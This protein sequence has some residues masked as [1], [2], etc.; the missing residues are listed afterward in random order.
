[1]G[2]KAAVA[3]M[4]VMRLGKGTE[5]PGLAQGQYKYR[6]DPWGEPT[7]VQ[8]QDLGVQTKPSPAALK[9][10]SAQRAGGSQMCP[11]PRGFWG[12]PCLFG[13][14]PPELW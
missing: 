12:C 14:P 1:M 13:K 9:A 6:S 8:D 4:E 7:P 5:W 11:A 3:E 2:L 10:S